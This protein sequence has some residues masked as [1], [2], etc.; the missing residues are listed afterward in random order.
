MPCVEVADNGNFARRGPGVLEVGTLA[1]KL[2]GPV[3]LGAPHG[4]PMIQHAV[5]AD[6]D[7]VQRID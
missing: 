6:A 2:E 1:P 7:V 5:A 4:F 3:I